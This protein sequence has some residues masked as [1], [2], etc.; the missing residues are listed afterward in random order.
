MTDYTRP[1]LA[2]TLE[3]VEL[4]RLP[5][6]V[7]AKLDGIRC[8]IDRGVAISRN[9]K[10][11]RNAHIQRALG[12]HEFYGLDGELI[13]GPPSGE[14]VFNRTT[15]GVMSESGTPDFTYWVFDTFFSQ[16]T[17]F[18][19]RYADLLS[20][21]LAPP[22]R[23]LPQRYVATLTELEDFERETLA[24]GF[25]GVMLRRPD[26][27]YKQGRSTLNEQILLRIKRFRDGEAK[28]VGY[29]EGRTNLNA[30]TLDALGYTERSTHAENMRPAGK[31]GT[32]ICED[33]KTG[34]TLRISPG[35]MSHDDRARYFQLPG[36]L[37]Y[38]N[39]KYKVFDYGSK[40]APRFATFQG[41]L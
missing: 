31:I 30:P 28:I 4:L 1:L 32:L 3:N 34:Q 13:V 20:Y 19:R 38:R 18:T 16:G 40:D 15:S 10:P 6:V 24:A 23:I 27:P 36:S 5:V 11:I 7:S 14:G 26:G 17:P 39:I 9:G 2:C 29:E 35:R 12:K 21:N 25:E 41:F 8:L 22:I 33:L 37:L